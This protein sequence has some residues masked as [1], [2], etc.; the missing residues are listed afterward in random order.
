RG[1]AFNHINVGSDPNTPMTRGVIGK[2]SSLDRLDESPWPTLRHLVPWFCLINRWQGGV[3]ELRDLAGIRCDN[4]PRATDKYRTAVCINRGLDR[5]N[6]PS[7]A[8]S[9]G[10]DFDFAGMQFAQTVKADTCGDEIFT[11]LIGLSFSSYES[12]DRCHMQF[13]ILPCATCVWCG[14]KIRGSHVLGHFDGLYPSK[15]RRI[16]YFSWFL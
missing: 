12:R 5:F 6:R 10:N 2:F 9:F 14:N 13:V 16:F 11:R 15:V 1:F 4:L 7:R 8:H 3:V